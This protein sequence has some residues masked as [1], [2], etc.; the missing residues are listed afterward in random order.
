MEVRLRLL[1]QLCGCAFLLALL[2]STAFADDSHDRT[3][4]GNDIIVGANEEVSEATCFGCSIHVR[5]H[6]IRDVTVFGGRIIVEDQGEIGGDATVFGGSVRLDKAVKVAG[7]I[8]VFGGRVRRD[9]DATV[10]GDVT[11]FG[12]SFWILLIVGLP[13]VLLAA[14]IAGIAWL[15]R[16]MTRPTLPAPA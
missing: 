12:S 9:P 3:H 16:R 15:V 10:G 6:V 2:S 14:F 13:F 8:T 4:F 11:T 5:G 1:F 7:G